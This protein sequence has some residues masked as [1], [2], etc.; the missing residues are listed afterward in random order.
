MAR[1]ERSVLSEIVAYALQYGGG[2]AVVMPE[3]V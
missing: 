3:A 2:I 1:I